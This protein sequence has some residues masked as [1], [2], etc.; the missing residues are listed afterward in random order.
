MPI[1][2]VHWKPPFGLIDPDA[3]FNLAGICRGSNETAHLHR[4][5]DEIREQGM[6][7]EGF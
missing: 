7:G 3:S 2:S 6:R 1:Q 5:P 4:C